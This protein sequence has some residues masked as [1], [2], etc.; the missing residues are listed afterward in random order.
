MRLP[1]QGYAGTPG[2]SG[3][4]GVPGPQGAPGAD[5]IGPPAAVSLVKPGAWPE[6]GCFTSSSDC[7]GLGVKD[8]LCGQ[9]VPLCDRCDADA[10]F[11][12]VN[13][14]GLRF[15][16]STFDDSSLGKGSIQVRWPGGL[17]GFVS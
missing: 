6:G 12:L 13:P 14:A 2:A 4:V 3:P 17:R 10:G 7:V 11:K 5:G 16:G 9:C 15:A 1:R 8:N